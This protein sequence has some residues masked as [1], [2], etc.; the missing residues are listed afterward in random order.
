MIKPPCR[1]CGHVHTT[2]DTWAIGRFSPS[3]LAAGYRANYPGAPVR[4][5]REKAAKDMCEW[6]K[7]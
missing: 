3:G 6:R 4:A 2:A 1:D 5:S 7:R